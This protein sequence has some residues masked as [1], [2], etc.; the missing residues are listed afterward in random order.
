M[1]VFYKYI[2]PLIQTSKQYS[3][4]Q[5]LSKQRREGYQLIEGMMW[6]CIKI[7]S[8]VADTNINYEEVFQLIDGQIRIT[9]DNTQQQLALALELLSDILAPLKYRSLAA[10]QLIKSLAG[11]LDITSANSRQLLMSIKGL[12]RLA[13]ND[14][15]KR[16]FDKNIERLISLS[17][18]QS[19]TKE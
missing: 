11:L 12:S 8:K 5:T 17:E 16:V 3:E 10:E 4:Q 19:L 13:P 2:F 7:F 15:I 1:G 6:R 14:Y 9:N 18:S